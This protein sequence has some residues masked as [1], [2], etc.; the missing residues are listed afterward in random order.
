MVL[1][2]SLKTEDCSIVLAA[3]IFDSPPVVF[4]AGGYKAKG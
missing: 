4:T 1:V 2:F 3:S